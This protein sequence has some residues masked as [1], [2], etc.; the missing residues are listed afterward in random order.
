MRRA[1]R[2]YRLVE[3]LRGREVTTAEVLAQTLEVSVRT[4]YRDIAD[5]AGSGLPV[6]GEPGVGYRL[7]RGL[8]LPPLMFDE[9]EVRS[10]VLG[11]RMVEAWADAPLRQAAGSVLRKVRA[12]LPD[13]KRGLLERTALF[14][15]SFLAPRPVVERMG[16]C[17]AAVEGQLRLR[18]R[19]Q[20]GQGAQTER[21]LRP[22]GLFFW[23]GTWTVGGWCELRE[24]HRGFRI[25]RMEALVL[26]VRFEPGEGEGLEAFLAHARGS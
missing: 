16:V 23:G 9:D 25:D 8:E 22:V 26:G 5:L 12:M 6:E 21:T 14:A 11:A 13:T 1:D 19:Y 20:D 17:R 24:A 18:F 2:L 10:L 15:P 7:G 4:I 3:L